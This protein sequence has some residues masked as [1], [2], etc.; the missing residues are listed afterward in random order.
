MKADNRRLDIVLDEIFAVHDALEKIAGLL[1]LAD[2]LHCALNSEPPHKSA[3][4]L[5][6][7]AAREIVSGWARRAA[8]QHQG[9]HA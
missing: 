9:K 5:K 7:E 1:S 8:E 6:A 3:L 4:T 2:Q